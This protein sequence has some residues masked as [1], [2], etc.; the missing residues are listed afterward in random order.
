MRVTIW[1][2]LVGYTCVYICVYV[3]IYV[4]IYICVCVYAYIYIH[5]HI[6]IYIPWRGAWQ[7]TPVFLPG[8]ILWTEKTGRLQ[9]MWSQTVGHDW[10]NL[11]HYT[12]ICVYVWCVYIYRWG[13]PGSSAGKESSC[14]AGDPRSIPGLGRSPGERLGY[15]LQ[16]PCLKNPMDRGAWWTTV[17]GVTKSQ[18]QLS[19]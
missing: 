6:C 2:S 5:T 13:F 8:E 7:P 10:S 9:S 16:Y 14:T 11:S 18:T 17:H 3:Y 15:S 4:C 12:Y 1:L 19:D